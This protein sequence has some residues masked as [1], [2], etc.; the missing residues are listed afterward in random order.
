MTTRPRDSGR[1][2]LY[3]AERLVHHMFDRAAS[4]RTVQI[5]GTELTL[6]VEAHFGS[7]ASVR[8]YVD[9]VLAMPSVRARFRRA[10][11]PV[12]VRERRGHRSAEYLRSG[13]ADPQIAIPSSADGRWALRE[14]VVLHEIAHHLDDS[15]GPAH[16]RE[17]AVGLT[18]L[19]GLVLGPEAGFVYRVVFGD[20]GVV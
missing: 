20:S 16:G 17:F 19:V 7:V 10:A 11:R 18:D 3:E 13:D 9:R 5:A 2:R 1:A 6:P 12:R 14:L 8:D 15:S 4:N